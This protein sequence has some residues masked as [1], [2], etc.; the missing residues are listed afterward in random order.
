M[1]MPPPQVLDKDLAETI[2]LIMAKHAPAPAP[3]LGPRQLG[4]AQA[5][6]KDVAAGH[7]EAEERAAA[8]VALRMLPE[9]QVSVALPRPALPLP[10]LPRLPIELP[11]PCCLSP[12]GIDGVGVGVC[13]LWTC[14]PQTFSH[15]S[16]NH[17]LPDLGFYATS[18]EGD[19]PTR[20][21]SPARLLAPLTRGDVPLSALRLLCSALTASGA[22]RHDAPQRAARIQTAMQ[23]GAQCQRCGDAA[24]VVFATPC[25]HLLCVD[26]TSGDK[27]ACP[28]CQE[29]Y[30]MQARP[31]SRVS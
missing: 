12:A 1:Q 4:M 17:E 11:V 20:H 16:G 13:L 2:W 23:Q 10:A 29:P 15:A 8:A 22:L 30:A 21:L 6:L 5:Q 31:P 14:T 19:G 28:V 27:R 26:C 18:Q 3:Q 9:L 25:C 24:R 7:A